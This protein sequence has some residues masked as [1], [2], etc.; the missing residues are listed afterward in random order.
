MA[1]NSQDERLLVKGNERITRQLKVGKEIFADC[2]INAACDVNI[3]GSL[4]TDKICSAGTLD[5]S[6]SCVNVNATSLEVNA[7]TCIKND[8][9]VQCAVNTCNLQVNG[10]VKN[11]LEVEGDIRGHQ[12]IIAECDLVVHGNLLVDGNVTASTET[13]VA[14]T[15]DY[16]VTR[17]NNNNALTSTE[18]SGLAVNNY[19]NGKMATLTSDYCGTWRVSDSATNTGTTYTNVSEFNGH[20]YDHLT[21][22]TTS[23]PT[24]V[25]TDVNAIE[26]SNVVLY[27]GSYYHKEGEDWFGPI[28]VV[29][30]IFDLGSLITDSA[31]ITALNA[32][33]A[34]ELIYYNTVKDN[35]INVSQN[36]PLLTRAEESSLQ[37]NDILVWD[38]TNKK[39]VPMTRPTVSGSNLTAN[40]NGATSCVT[41]TWTTGIT[42]TNSICFNGCTYAQ[43]KA[44]ILSGNAASATNA[45][46]FNGCTFAQ[47]CTTIRSGL[48]SCVGTVTIADKAAAN[49]N[50]PVALCTGATSVGKSGSCG[51]NFNTCTGELTTTQVS[52]TAA[53]ATSWSRAPIFMSAGASGAS[54]VCNVVIR[55]CCTNASCA[56]TCRNFVFCGSTGY[57]HGNVCGIATNANSAVALSTVLTVSTAAATAAKEATLAG[58]SLHK[59]A[60]LTINLTN[61]NTVANATLNI[62]GTGAKAVKINGAAVTASN[63]SAGF[64]NA[65]YDGTY[66]QLTTYEAYNAYTAATATSATCATKVSRNG[67]TSAYNFDVA[68]FNN[69]TSVNSEQMYVS[70]SCRLNYCNTTGALCITNNARSAVAGSVTAACVCTNGIQFNSSHNDTVGIRFIS[71]IDGPA[72]CALFK[73]ITNAVTFLVS[74]KAYAIWG[75][76]GTKKLDYIC[77]ASSTCYTFYSENTCVGSVCCCCTSTVNTMF[78][79]F[80]KYIY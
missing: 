35:H 57:M 51:L 4:N 17:E 23:G 10:T 39:A 71:T 80:G 29:N 58:F 54:K 19:S 31:T 24:G 48:T 78:A 6:A 44:D 5:I 8:L 40:I 46:Q 27:N 36:Q 42:A 69:S 53:V 9:N 37:N 72:Q 61:A 22:T 59:G 15:G 66:W 12:D 45:T 79:I 62:N 11:R 47:A 74:G 26:L 14:T 20:F 55:A 33:T 16:L 28:S 63:W 7:A 38:N 50:T 30:G 56:L 67:Y 75:A 49:S 60:R 52:V 77:R 21:Q 13:Q 68:L 64:W 18:Y 2:D 70:N 34:H 41:Y 73:D 43:A 65:Y 32:L 25:M 76:Y 1:Y 3:T